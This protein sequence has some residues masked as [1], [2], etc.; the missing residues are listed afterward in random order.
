LAKNSTP[1]SLTRLK[2]GKVNFPCLPTILFNNLF[3][4]YIQATPGNGWLTWIQKILG[5]ISGTI[6]NEAINLMRTSP[7]RVSKKRTLPRD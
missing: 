4:Y 5:V 7:V 6:S 1:D 3:L 2:E